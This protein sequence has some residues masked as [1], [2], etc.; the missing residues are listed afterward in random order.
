MTF[1][2]NI[3]RDAQAK[4]ILIETA[5][6]GYVPAPLTP[7]APS[8]VIEQHLRSIGHHGHWREVN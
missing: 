3:K 6:H 1:T 7:D 5:Q 4:C 8:A 2:G